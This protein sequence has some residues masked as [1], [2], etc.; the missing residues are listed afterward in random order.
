MAGNVM[1]VMFSEKIA[2]YRPFNFR[3]E[4]EVAGYHKFTKTDPDMMI[5]CEDKTISFVLQ[6]Y[7]NYKKWA[8][9]DVTIKLSKVKDLAGNEML[10]EYKVNFGQF[11][12]D[13]H[14]TAVKAE[15]HR[16]DHHTDDHHTD[17]HHTDDHKTDDH[18]TDDHKTDDHFLEEDVRKEIG[19]ATNLEDV[20]RIKFTNVENSFLS[21]TVD[22]AQDK[23]DLSALEVVDNLYESISKK[24]LDQKE[25]PYL[26]RGTVNSFLSVPIPS[27]ADRTA[28]ETL[29]AEPKEPASL[30]QT[31]E[32]SSASQWTT[33]HVLLLSLLGIV[34]LVLSVNTFVWFRY[35]KKHA[36]YTPVAD[37]GETA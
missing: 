18:K 24:K 16:D 12:I 2:C 15:V 23:D 11:K 10:N 9:K 21:F 14:S 32:E 20:S 1:K 34:A 30:L 36:E 27:D 7:V 17:D 25:F 37:A 22:P 19:R 13:T 8:G 29:A 35:A 3:V 33:Y 28:Y 31:D 4:V 26:S 5:L 6:R